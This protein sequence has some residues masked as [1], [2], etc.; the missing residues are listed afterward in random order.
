MPKIKFGLSDVHI[1]EYGVDTATTPMVA[2]PGA[3]SLVY[4]PTV[5]QTPFYADNI[6][7][8]IL[9]GQAQIT[10]SLEMALI[11]NTIKTTY[12]GYKVTTSGALVQQTGLQDMTPFNLSFKIQHDDAQDVI[13]LYN[14]T[15]G[16]ISEEH[17]TTEGQNIT[18]T[19]ET[20]PITITG[21]TVTKTWKMVVPS[22]NAGYATALTNPEDPIAVP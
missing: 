15:G 12:L 5:E 13:V 19:T 16:A 22:T 3:V 2:V 4:E 10:G 8:Y 14:V 17:R 18:P 20:L 7:Y 21:D 6:A 9:T 11:P 1:G